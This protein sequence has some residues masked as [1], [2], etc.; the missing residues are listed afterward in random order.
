MDSGPATRINIASLVLV[1][2]V[3]FPFTNV[4]VLIDLSSASTQHK[5]R[6]RSSA[7]VCQDE[8]WAA[9]SDLPIPHLTDDQSTRIKFL[10]PSGSVNITHH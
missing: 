4:L 2:Y 6:T 5:N 10:K 8:A 7:E 3:F 9:T 1:R